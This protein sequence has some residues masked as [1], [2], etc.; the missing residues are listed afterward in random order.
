MSP[1]HQPGAGGIGMQ[2]YREAI[3]EGPRLPISTATL[4]R[5]DDPGF[6]V[7][8][9]VTEMSYHAFDVSGKLIRG[10]RSGHSTLGPDALTCSR[11]EGTGNRTSIR[12]RTET[13]E[14]LCVLMDV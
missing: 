6:T 1:E 3:A 4:E 5:C 2:S 14:N 11:A 8:Y 9:A 7:E 13:S 12:G 10:W